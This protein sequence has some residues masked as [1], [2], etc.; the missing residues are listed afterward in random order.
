MKRTLKKSQSKTWYF[1]A[2]KRVDGVP[3]G[4]RGNVDEAELTD[5]D[6][7]RGVNISELIAED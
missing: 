1:V 2:G 3:S 6:R 7:E 5:E 4:L